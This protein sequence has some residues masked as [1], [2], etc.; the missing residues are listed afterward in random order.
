MRS[1]ALALALAIFFPSADVL[2]STS[3]PRKREVWRSL[4]H[5]RTDRGRNIDLAA[6][7]FRYAVSASRD[8]SAWSTTAIDPASVAIVD[9]DNHQMYAA[10]A[11]QREALGLAHARSDRLDVAVGRL[12]MRMANHDPR[13]HVAL[14]LEA[15]A[16]IADLDER[17]ELPL[18][19]LGNGASAYPRL[20]V[21]GTVRIGNESLAVRGT[22]WIDHVLGDTAAGEDGWDRFVVAFDDG[23]VLLVE[24]RRN[25]SG[26]R[27]NVDGGIFVDR[28]GAVHRLSAGDFT[29]ENPL[30]TN[31]LS[32]RTHARYPSLWEISVPSAGLDL[33]LIPP[34][35]NQEIVGEGQ[36]QS[37][38]DGALTVERFPPPEHTDRGRG[39]VE[40]T[41][42]VP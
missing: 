39:F 34:I 42:Y 22:G 9:E 7:F 32:V 35:Q 2:A 1:L 17:V 31:W 3:V 28:S 37:F 41:G 5:V 38:Y 25:A 40:L 15:G 13:A 12:W 33:A 4:I 23:R 26:V 11:V 14:H 20:A 19:A 18:I 36:G 16:A 21:R 27:T 29:V 30:S 24:R 10:S 6:I 8:G